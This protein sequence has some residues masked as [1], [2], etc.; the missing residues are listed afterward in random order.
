MVLQDPNFS[1]TRFYTSWATTK[2]GA[3]QEAA[4][5]K[6]EQGEFFLPRFVLLAVGFDVVCDDS[7]FHGLS[8][9]PSTQGR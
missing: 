7:Q 6:A 2:P 1:T 9:V 4:R 8:L 3:A 5:E